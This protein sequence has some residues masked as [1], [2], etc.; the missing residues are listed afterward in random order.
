MDKKS[1]ILVLGAKG[2]LGMDLM[3]IFAQ[4]NPIG[5]DTNDIN[6]SD[7]K[8]VE[9]KITALNPDIIINLAAYTNVDGCETN[10]EVCFKVNGD[11]IGFLAQTCKKINAIIV[12]ISTDY[13]F[14][15]KNSKGYEEDSPTNPINAY[16][17]SKLVGEKLIKDA[18][19]YYLIRTSWLFGVNGNNFVEK[20][21]K[22][23]QENDKIKVVDDQIGSPTYTIHLAGKI[24]ELLEKELPFGTYHITNSGVCSWFEFAR[25]IVSTSN[26]NADVIPV[27]TEEFP[28]PAKRPKCSVLLNTK[29][30]GNLPHWKEALKDYINEK[31]EGVT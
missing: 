21:S 31:K 1:K 3:H 25:E 10:K 9:E 14:D 15:G 27:K 23:A 12:H 19:R 4:Y 18:S 6:I 29:L 13:V 28:T 20:I 26:L 24:K 16:G 8:Q 11:A 5:W 22:I 30:S 7:K 17:E 2:M